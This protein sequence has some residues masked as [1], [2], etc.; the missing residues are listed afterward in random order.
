MINNDLI[1]THLHVSFI[2]VFFLVIN[3]E[4][5]TLLWH[6]SFHY[7]KNNQETPDRDKT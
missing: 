1:M 4:N 6:D 5:M 7:T 2:K 3:V